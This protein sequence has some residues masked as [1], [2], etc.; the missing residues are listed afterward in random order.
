MAFHGLFG[1]K[2]DA[3]VTHKQFDPNRVGLKRHMELPR[4]AVADRIPQRLLQ[5]TKQANGNLRRQALLNALGVKFNLY[6]L[7]AGK[8][9]AKAGSRSGESKNLQLRR[10]QPV[11]YGAEVTSKIV[12]LFAYFNN[13][14]LEFTCRAQ[15]IL[16]QSV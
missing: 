13:L 2:T 5:D 16:L 11:R 12:D 4:T 7:V 14:P 10:V 8:L 6:S 1:I 3:R 9:S 15:R